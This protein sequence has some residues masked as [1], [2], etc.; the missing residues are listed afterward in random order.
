[1]TRRTFPD[2]GSRLVY[3][4]SGTAFRSSVATQMKVYSDSG[5]T[6]LADIQTTGGATISG[7]VITADSGSQLPLFLGPNDSSDTLYV[8]KADG[9]GSVSAIY[10]RADDRLD[11]VETRATA[12]ESVVYVKTYIPSPDGTTDNSSALAS[13]LAA[14]AGKVLEF[15]TGKTYVQNSPL[16][17][18]SNTV[19][20]GNGA[21]LQ[22]GTSKS[23]TL[24][25]S[26]HQLE[27]T[28]VSNV[29]VEGLRFVA[30]ASAYGTLT[31]NIT[32]I[33]LASATNCVVRNC[34]FSSTG[35]RWAIFVTTGS[36][37]CR[38]ENNYSDGSGITYSNGGASRVI[39]RA[40]T[41]LNAEQNGLSCT[42]NNSGAYA[43][44]CIAEDNYVINA[45]RMGIEDW[46]YTLGSVIRN[47]YVS[48]A[49]VY[50]ISAV[51]R[52]TLVE[53][54]SVV[55]PVSSYCIE[56]T[57]DGMRVVGNACRYVSAT[58]HTGIVVNNNAGGVWKGAELVGN[59]LEGCATGVAF[60]SASLSVVIQGNTLV[61]CVTG[62]DT[63]T[64]GHV[65]ITGNQFRWTLAGTGA[66]VGVNVGLN[67][68][69][70]N[71][72]F[73][74]ESGAGGGSGSMNCVR[75]T[76]TADY[77][78]ISGNL[79]D[80]GSVS[81][82]S[83]PV[84]VSSNGSTPT[85]VRITGNV[86]TGGATLSL[87][88]LVSPVIFGNTGTTSGVKVA[89]VDNSFVVGLAALATNATDGF[90]Y[91]PSCAGTPTGT[92]T[93]QT[94]TVPLVWDSTNSKLYVYS[95]GAWKGGTA[96]GAFS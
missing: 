2:E 70:A 95:G 43:T 87:S 32:S 80:A 11:A 22:A 52:N 40:N 94:G 20:R 5:A 34:T 38:V 12:L 4:I 79:F 65:T 91:I 15:E 9:T 35:V 57:A 66:R 51:G 84:G 45:G 16:L 3:A 7:S 56:T 58:A 81:S 64:S 68:V 67:T 63:P 83:V 72:T 59:Y 46:T 86:F 60:V 50:G 14:A 19:V 25:S 41:I 21:T 23:G 77:A 17:P 27:L 36:S 48:G 42:G 61:D 1:M 13:A 76:S 31:G 33:Q 18:A 93:T 30:P 78:L 82:P 96:P 74:W 89:K 47:N 54:N 75:P 10:A 73:A 37:D 28:S 85:G 24:S 69:V 92:P 44:G 6:T 29:V 88:N 53:G 90:L 71:N 62:I 8:K 39:C 26:G 55:D 49:T